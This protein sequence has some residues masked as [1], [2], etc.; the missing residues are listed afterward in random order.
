MTD[1]GLFADAKTEKIY[2][3]SR[4]VAD[5]F[6]KEHKHILESIREILSEKSGISG[7]FGRSNFRPIDYKD[8]HGRKQPRYA[9]SR[10]GFTLLVMG[11]TGQ[12]AM[13]FK[14]YYITKFNDMEATLKALKPARADYPL[15][16][17]QIRLSHDHPKFYH[18]T[19]ESDMIN[20]IVLG[21]T[22]KQYKLDHGISEGEKS[23][24]PYL[25]AEELNLID[26]LQML[27]AGM[28]AGGMSFEQR[29]VALTAS[30]VRKGVYANCISVD[31]PEDD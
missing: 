9:L 15:M 29:K 8:A 7:E 11:F 21:K 1:D 10:D 3:D 22:S 31:K 2:C 26:Y 28:I 6:E 17:E 27:N 5:T 13:K 20:R 12:K 24:R 25:T 16:T 14:E 4:Y 30:A 19:N 23:V 18:Y